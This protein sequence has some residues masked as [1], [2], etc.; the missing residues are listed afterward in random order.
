LPNRGKA[1]VNSPLPIYDQEPTMVA[2]DD[3]LSKEKEIDKLM[4]LISLSFKK[5]YKPTNNNLITSSDTS[6]E[7]HNNTPRIN[8]GT[9]YDNQMAINVAGA[10]EN[11]GIQVVQQ[12]R[13]QCYNCKEYGRV[14]KECQKPKQAK[15]AA[16]H[17]EKMLLYQELE[18]HYLFMAQIQE[19]TSDAA[20]NS[21]P[22]FDT[23]P[24]QKVQPD[25]DEYNVFANDRQ[26]P[27]Q[28]KYVN[29]TYLNEQGDT[30][31][32]T[33]SLDMGTNGEE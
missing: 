29:D 5:I 27:E 9:Q 4:A 16:Y 30:N 28:P 18:A 12:S 13:I 14:A 3:A 10:R 26:H 21:G 31:I 6:R 1:I 33:D 15:D 20:D 11:V 32:L 2:K 17:K 22:I 8:K 24:L 19:V 23:E 25:N 7:N